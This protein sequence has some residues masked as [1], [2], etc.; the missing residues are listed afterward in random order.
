MHPEPWHTGRSDGLREPAAVTIGRALL[1]QI[2]AG[3]V[4][5]DQII[6][7]FPGNLH[8][9]GVG[10]DGRHADLPRPVGLG[11]ADHDLAADPRGALVHM[12]PVTPEIDVADTQASRLTP[13]QSAETQHEHQGPVVTARLSQR[14]QLFHGEEHVPA[15]R[16]SRQHRVLRGCFG[17][18]PVLD[19]HLVDA[20]EDAERAVDDR[21]RPVPCEFG[22]HCCTSECLMPPIGRSPQYGLTYTRHEVSTD[23]R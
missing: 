22:A 18:P 6:R 23:F 10:N 2:A 11:A 12:D 16:L 3:P 20:F 19:R 13:T 4:V 15:G 14:H 17:D 21:G 7:S 1:P 9:Q 8:T 5:E